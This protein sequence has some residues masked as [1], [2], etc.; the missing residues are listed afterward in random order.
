[1]VLLAPWVSLTAAAAPACNLTGHWKWTASS[2]LDIEIAM[3]GAN[4][5]QV[6]LHPDTVSVS[7]F[8]VV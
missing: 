5:F 8:A 7:C 1:M 6:V 4:T 2:R 3:T